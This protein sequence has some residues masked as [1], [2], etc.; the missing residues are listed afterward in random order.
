[1]TWLKF[2]LWLLGIY[3]LYYAVLIFWDRQRAGKSAQSGDKHELTFVEHIEPIKSFIGELLDLQTSPIVSHGGVS[4]K[5]VFSLAREEA[6]EY[7]RPV[8]FY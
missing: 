5:E 1:M 3:S 7:I 6:I 8:S 4:L 2:A